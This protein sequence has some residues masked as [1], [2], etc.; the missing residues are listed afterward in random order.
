MNSRIDN[1]QNT[2][3]QGQPTTCRRVSNL[4]HQRVTA[5]SK[6]QE[7]GRPQACFRKPPKKVVTR[8]PISVRFAFR[9]ADEVDPFEPLNGRKL[10]RRARDNTHKRS[11]TSAHTPAPTLTR[12]T[13]GMCVRK[14]TQIRTTFDT[15]KF[16]K[17]YVGQSMNKLAMLH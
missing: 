14:R 11:R 16:M 8:T 17:T 9:G 6:R 7:F 10:Y 1:L 12:H 4:Y 5:I 3:I 15:D 13:R 2:H